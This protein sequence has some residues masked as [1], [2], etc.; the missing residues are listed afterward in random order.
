MFFLA[1][2]SFFVSGFSGH[3]SICAGR[4]ADGAPDWRRN[5][6]AGEK[7]QILKERTNHFTGESSI[8]G[9]GVEP[10]PVAGARTRSGKDDGGHR[11]PRAFLHKSAAK[12]PKRRTKGEGCCR[13]R[14]IR[15]R[16]FGRCGRLDSKQLADAM[17][18]LAK[19]GRRPRPKTNR[20]PESSSDFT[21]PVKLQVIAEQLQQLAE[22]LK[23]CKPAN[24]QKSR[25]WS[26]RS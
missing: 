3:R 11:S 17:A 24:G 21:M 5:A 22:A 13:N 9:T 8:P 1:S 15:G 25:N 6:K 26:R 23:K 20:L 10:K 12:A 7:L 18:E 2:V 19:M 16:A 4:R 14:T